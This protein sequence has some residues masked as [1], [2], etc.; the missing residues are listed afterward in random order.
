MNIITDTGSLLSREKAKDLGLELLPLQVAVKGKSYR[1]YFEIS[2]KDFVE[3]IKDA[4]PAS[5][6]PSIG[7]VMEVY[8]R[9]R[10]SVV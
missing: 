10:K 7:D 2:A 9:D 3:M 6:Q 8:E 5:S 1:D 4:I